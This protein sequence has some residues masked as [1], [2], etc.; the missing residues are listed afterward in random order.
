MRTFWPVEKVWLTDQPSTFAWLFIWRRGFAIPHDMCTI[1]ELP[2][3]CHWG[4]RVMFEYPPHSNPPCACYHQPIRIIIRVVSY[5]FVF[6]PY[7]ERVHSC[8]VRYHSVLFV[9][10]RVTLLLLT[11]YFVLFSCEIL[12]HE[13][14]SIQ[15]EWLEY[16]T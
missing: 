9:S 10:Y 15:W 13:W 7:Y 11:Y 3:S 14:S 16:S 2:Q 4:V 1:T 5:V 12:K 8:N 6:F